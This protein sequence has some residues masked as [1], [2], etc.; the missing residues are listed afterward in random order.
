MFVAASCLSGGYP[1]LRRMRFTITRSFA[2]TD[3]FTVQSMVAF[4]R[5]VSTSSRAIVLSVS[6]PRTFTALSLTSSAS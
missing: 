3:S 6:S 5:T 1:Y 4:R 2:R